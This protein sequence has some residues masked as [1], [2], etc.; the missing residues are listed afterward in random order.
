MATTNTHATTH[1]LAAFFGRFAIVVLI[2]A[3]IVA[4]FFLS[5]GFNLYRD[6]LTQTS[7]EDMASSIRSSEGFTPLDELPDL[8]L[9]AVIAVE[10]HRF[11]LHPGFDIIS[12]TRALVNDLK[13]GSIVEGGSTI[14]Q[15]LA[16][17]QY[18][19]QAQTLE[20]KI[21]EVFMALSMEQHFSKRQILELYVNSIYFGDGFTGIG[22]ASAGYFDKT[23]RALSADECTL[24]AG[25]PNAPSAYALSE[26]SDLARQ[27]QKHVLDKLVAYDYL[28][29]SDVSSINRHA[30][31]A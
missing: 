24:L 4:A 13:A 19:T 18:F 12:T 1:F 11:Y 8:Y 23:P 20:R 26:N 25:I 15:Q 27:R 5:R 31:L 3:A 29:V 30:S 14:T 16:K 22:N 17:N 9:Q 2:A 21:A 7:F 6:A 28:E 10:D